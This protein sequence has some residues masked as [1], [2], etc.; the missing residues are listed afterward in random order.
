[1]KV[2]LTAQI[3]NLGQIGDVIEVRNGY[4]KNFLIPNQKAICF[5]PNSQKLFD[6]RK[7]EFQKAN[8]EKLALAQEV[9]TKLIGQN[10]IVIENAS[11]DGRL[12]GSVNAALIAEKI[13]KIVAKKAV[14]KTDVTLLNPIKDIGVYLV[15]IDLHPEV[16][17]EV[18]V[19][20]SRVESEV[21]ALLKAHDKAKKDAA[22]AEEKSKEKPKKEASEEVAAVVE[23]KSAE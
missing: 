4:A 23:E 10:I 1:M 5:T 3:S 14:E 6:A 11:D 18:K 16:L 21:D 2:I 15:K 7:A 17:L 20:V 19:V 13:N 12:Y 8:D 22:V 9:K